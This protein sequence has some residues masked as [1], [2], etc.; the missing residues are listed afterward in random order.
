MSERCTGLAMRLERT[1]RARRRKN[2]DARTGHHRRTK[3]RLAAR[4]LV[5][6]STRHDAAAWSGGAPRARAR[7][8]V[9]DRREVEPGELDGGAKQRPGKRVRRDDE[10][11]E[12][13]HRDATS[14]V[15]SRQAPSLGLD[16]RSG[17]TTAD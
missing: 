11:S 5:S 17:D 1:A 7:P 10:Y 2:G 3:K 8:H 6:Q 9:D 15:P 13:G 14:K 4:L 16:V 12:R